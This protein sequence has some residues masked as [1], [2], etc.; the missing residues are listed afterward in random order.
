MWRGYERIREQCRAE[1]LSKAAE[2]YS[3][4]HPGCADLAEALTGK[5]PEHVMTPQQAEQ[6][7]CD[8]ETL[9]RAR[10]LDLKGIPCGVN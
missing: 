10:L 4:M 2:W 7:Q 6:E 5:R 9:Y 3:P 1:V 8:I